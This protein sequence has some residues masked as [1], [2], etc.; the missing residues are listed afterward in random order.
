MAKVQLQGHWSVS[1][2]W[3]VCQ[4]WAVCASVT[5]RACR[6]WMFAKQHCSLLLAISSRCQARCCETKRAVTPGPRCS[7]ALSTLWTLHCREVLVALPSRRILLGAF[8]LVGYV[9]V[10]RGISRA[11]QLHDSIMSPALLS[12]LVWPV[13]PASLLLR[14]PLHAAAHV[15]Y[16]S[17]RHHLPNHQSAQGLPRGGFGAGRT[18]VCRSTSWWVFIRHFM[19]DPYPCCDTLG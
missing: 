18:H 13:H 5:K 14:P 6:S 3:Q 16:P 1:G 15:P 4:L 9:G 10:K 7:I 11:V 12:Y 19:Q 2:R 8:T 17:Q